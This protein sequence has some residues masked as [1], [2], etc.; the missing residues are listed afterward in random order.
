MFDNTASQILTYLFFIL[1]PSYLIFFF[2]I[3]SSRIQL[4]KILIYKSRDLSSSL[5]LLA[6]TDFNFTMDNAKLYLTA[7]DL[8]RK[9]A[10]SIIDEFSYIFK[11]YSHNSK[12]IDIGCGPGD[13]LV[14]YL[15]P[16]ILSSFNTVIG[17][18]KSLEMV[19]KANILYGDEQLQFHRMDIERDTKELTFFL[20]ES[21]EIVTS[22]FCLHWIQ[23]RR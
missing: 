2:F 4:L 12:L 1:S 16:K 8:Q 6:R 11:N 20:N 9:D 23:N 22:F 5:S 10:K 19:K 21:A 14:D 3:D 18:D 17:L 13:V 15:L 7:N